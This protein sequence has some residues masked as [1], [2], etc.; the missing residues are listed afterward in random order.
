MKID[1]LCQRRNCSPLNVLFSDVCID[2]V[3]IA[4]RSCGMGVKQRWDGKNKS[5][6]THGRRALTWR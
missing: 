3:D 1:P 2:C 5:S 6:Y 4:R